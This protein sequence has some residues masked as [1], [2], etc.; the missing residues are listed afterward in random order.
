VLQNCLFCAVMVIML[1]ELRASHIG[2]YFACR[3]GTA[4]KIDGHVL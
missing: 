1:Y 3:T 2:G 4:G